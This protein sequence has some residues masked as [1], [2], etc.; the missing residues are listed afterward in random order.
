MSKILLHWHMIRTSPR[1]SLWIRNSAIVPPSTLPQHVCILSWNKQNQAKNCHLIIHSMTQTR[2]DLYLRIIKL[3]SENCQPQ[4]SFQEHAVENIEMLSA[5]HI[6]LHII[7]PWN[8]F[9]ERAI[10]N[11]EILS[12]W[13]IFYIWLNWFIMYNKYHL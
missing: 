1:H 10:E 5:W 2:F 13:H 9:Q 7:E 8:S 6:S 12:A 3:H 11:I 4:N